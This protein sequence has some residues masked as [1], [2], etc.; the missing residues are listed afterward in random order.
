MLNIRSLEG[1]HWSLKSGHINSSGYKNFGQIMLWDYLPGY[2]S[3]IDSW[4]AGTYAYQ[5]FEMIAFQK[6]LHTY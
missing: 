6:I 1:F 5:G 4:I 2:E 3:F